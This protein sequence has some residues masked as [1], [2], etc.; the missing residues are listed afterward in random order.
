[1][2]MFDTISDKLF[3]P[4]CGKQNESDSFQTKDLGQQMDT[5]TIAEILE[6]SKGVVRFVKI[7]HQC[8]FC[9]KWIEIDIKIENEDETC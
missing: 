9:N 1:M 4:Y 6:H 2:G 5:W 7:Y 3:C 8:E